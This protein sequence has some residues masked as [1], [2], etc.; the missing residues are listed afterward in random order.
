MIIIINVINVND[1]LIHLKVNSAYCKK[2]K[3]VLIVKDS[4]LNGIEESKLS[5]TRHIW[6]QPIPN[7]KVEDINLKDLLH[8][9]LETVTIHDCTTDATSDTP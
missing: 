9:D 8:E 7:G 1:S 2:K 4:M 5:K 3:T 6:V